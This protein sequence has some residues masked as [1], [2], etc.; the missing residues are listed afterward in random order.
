MVSGMLRCK[1]GI[2]KKTRFCFR[3]NKNH[4]LYSAPWIHCFGISAKHCNLYSEG[5]RISLV[6]GHRYG[7]PI[8]PVQ[9]GETLEQFADQYEDFFNMGVTVYQRNT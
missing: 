6:I 8:W 1:V 9:V 5:D 7:S 4:R 3:C 2:M